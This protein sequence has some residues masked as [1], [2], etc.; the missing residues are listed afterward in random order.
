MGLTPDSVLGYLAK[1]H[2]VLPQNTELH[3][4]ERVDMIKSAFD[5]DKGGDIDVNEF[6]NG[7]QVF[8]DPVKSAKKLRVP[9]R[10]DQPRTLQA[11]VH[12]LN[13]KVDSMRAEIG[14][15]KALIKEL[16]SLDRPR[17]Q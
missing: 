14:E 11:N 7:L 2:D 15:L 5:K 17:P 1:F 3:H 6:W 8:M 16:Y 13:S 4:E 10:T 12:N 9:T